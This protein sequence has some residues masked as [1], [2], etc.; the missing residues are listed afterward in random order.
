MMTD[1]DLDSKAILNGLVY[2]DQHKQLPTSGAAPG[3]SGPALPP[4]AVSEPTRQRVSPA[5][6]GTGAL[7]PITAAAAA[8][9]AVATY[10]GQAATGSGGMSPKTAARHFSSAGPHAIAS[11]KVETSA[12][13]KELARFRACDDQT[14][15]CFYCREWAQWVYRK[16]ISPQAAAAA[17]AASGGGVAGGPSAGNAGRKKKNKAVGGPPSA[18]GAGVAAQ[19]TQA[20]SAAEDA[21]TSAA[22]RKRAVRQRYT[23]VAE[24][25]ESLRSMVADERRL[26]AADDGEGTGSS[27]RPGS[28]PATAAATPTAA[29]SDERSDALG[30][31]TLINDITERV[32][33]WYEGHQF[34]LADVYEDLT[35]DFP[36]D[37]FPYDDHQDPLDPAL[38]LPALQVT[39]A[40]VGLPAADFAL[41]GNITSELIATHT[42]PTCQHTKADH[43]TPAELE[44][45]RLIFN[46]QLNKWRGDYRRSFEREMEPVWQITHLLLKSAQRIDAMRVR[47]FARGCRANRQQ[48][49]QTIRTRTMP[50]A[51]YWPTATA[52]LQSPEPAAIDALVA[53]H[54]DNLLEVSA[55]WSRTFLESYYGV[56]REFARELETILGECIT[57]CDR[58]AQGL[59]Y[60]PP[61][62]LQPQLDAAR[63]AISCLLPRL[64]ARIQRIQ[65]VVVERNAEIRTGTDE[66]RRLW[67][68]TSGATVQTKL[69][70]AGNKDLRKRI[71][72]I[73]YQQQTGVIAWAMRELELLLTAPD[74]AAVIADCLELLMTEAEILERAVAQVFVRKL[75]PN[76]DDLR[77]QR[78]DIIDDFTEGLLTG[79]EELAGVIGKL[80]LK[81][82]WRILEANISLQRQKALLDGSGSGGGSSSKSKKKQQQLQLQ[83]DPVAT[84][85]QTPTSAPPPG[86][87]DQHSIADEDDHDDDGD[88]SAVKKRKK[89][90]KKK[91]KKAKSKSAAAAAAAAKSQEPSAP[92]HPNPSADSVSAAEDEDDEEEEDGAGGSTGANGSR[93]DP[94]NPFDS[95]A[96]LS[97]SE[98][99]PQQPKLVPSAR[100]EGG[101]PTKKATAVAVAAAQ[102]VSQPALQIQTQVPQ[103][104]PPSTSDDGAL[105]K[106]ARSRRGTN[107]ARYVPGVGF[108]SDDGVSATSPQLAASTAT[109]GA[110]R[111]V[112]T[113]SVARV[114]VS[115]RMSPL[116]TVR[117]ASPAPRSQSPLVMGGAPPSS[118]RRALDIE[119][120]VKLRASLST[121]SAESI[122]QTL[123]GLSHDNLVCLAGAAIVESQVAV[124]SAVVWK[125]AVDRVVATYDLISEQVESVKAL[126][127]TQFTEAQRLETLLAQSAQESRKWQEQ[128]VRLSAELEALKSKPSPNAAGNLW[129]MGEGLEPNSPWTNVFYG[130]QGYPGGGSFGHFAQAGYNSSFAA[131]QAQAQAQAM[132][133]Q[134][135]DPLVFGDQPSVPLS[136]GSS[137]TSA[138]S[139]LTALNARSQAF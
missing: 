48:F 100:S 98:P 7:P 109:G 123:L 126:C 87:D 70:R 115:G 13:L 29:T 68:E 3:L 118:E 88:S 101:E 32:T 42:Y 137:D 45:Q 56:A 78:Q 133:Q 39:K 43:P 44:T 83:Q 77:E 96:W 65:R 55:T 90:K 128:C 82:A 12:V 6:A 67:E 10:Q 86:G 119:G 21:V 16:Q 106:V 116:S 5:A 72:R 75:E 91:N 124:D 46:A 37:A 54:L 94:Q 73:E 125:K 103:R 114:P 50:F 99:A 134:Q 111:G 71:K 27:S 51:E 69:A 120:L 11:L 8:A 60:P 130:Q 105:A 28:P 85:P 24:L 138:A 15:S 108:V 22:E 93:R 14:M 23:T 110:L 41:L 107:A 117:M 64:D 122:Q 80:M 95:L 131:I 59:K 40:F 121:E 81:E 74:V 132:A 20:A 53:E 1:L 113:G 89:N 25:C 57:M 18:S 31:S 49:L 136:G 34:P 36:A 66:V 19:Q 79:R 9:A 58:R 38:L 35:F 104:G 139:L 62:T 47:L 52:A 4:P 92:G 63:A 17:A 84:Q 2:L 61:L 33:L 30:S 76:A 97:P 127:E 112:V 129:S 26:L 135:R 102:P